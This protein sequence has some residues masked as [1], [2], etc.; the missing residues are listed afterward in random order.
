MFLMYYFVTF[1]LSSM[2]SFKDSGSPVIDCLWYLQGLCPLLSPHW[3]QILCFFSDLL[4][5]LRSTSLLTVNHLVL[6][7]ISLS[8]LS[9]Q[10]YFSVKGYENEKVDIVCELS[11]NRLLVTKRNDLSEI[12]M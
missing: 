11:G 8:F 1:C 9:T 2:N 3:S 5:V 10:L 6:E 4:C 7:H 12:L